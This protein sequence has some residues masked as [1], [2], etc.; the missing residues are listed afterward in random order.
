ML[1]SD[2]SSEALKVEAIEF[3]QRQY[4]ETC[5]QIEE[6]TGYLRG[7]ESQIRKLGGAIPSS[8]GLCEVSKNELTQAGTK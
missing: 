3:L 8:T 1:N 7:L 4:Q 6:R 2:K 5:R